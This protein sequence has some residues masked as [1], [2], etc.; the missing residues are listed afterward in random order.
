VELPFQSRRSPAYAAAA[1]LGLLVSCRGSDTGTGTG[2]GTASVSASAS[3]SERE[4]VVLMIGDG[5]GMEQVA[6]AGMFAH[7]EAGT[8]YFEGLPV[9]GTIDTTSL[10]GV[11][12]SAAAATAMACGVRCKNYRVGEDADGEAVPNLIELAHERGWRTG[13]VTTSSLPHATPAAFTSHQRSR[14]DFVGVA[15]DQALRAQPHVMLGGGAA[16]FAPAGPGSERSDDGLL[17]DLAEAGY[18][19]VA[20]RDELARA[21]RAERL[22]GAFAADHM[23]M[24][25]ER[26]PDTTQPTLAEMTAA[27]LQ[28]LD[29]G[30]PGMLLVV[31][32]G[33]IDHGGHDN[34]IA[35]VVAET[36]AFDEAV[37]TVDAATD[38]RATVIVTADHETG[39]LHVLEAR[40]AGTLPAVTWR[41]TEHTGADVGVWARN[42]GAPIADGQRTTHL[43][44]HEA[45]RAR[46][47]GDG[48]A[49]ARA[50]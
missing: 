23:D 22:F 45:I 24:V 26:A 8:L 1:A 14:Y 39:G 46:I 2:T 33:R 50:P 15:D 35:D 3:V 18:T 11:T 43:A 30:A 48:G 10:E 20:T 7:G 12:D 4:I 21:G 37:R 13:I 32:G 25:L 16:Y 49:T 31:E 36:L 41:T 47:A 27:A 19:I 34:S 40:G 28:A 44:I 5:M 17:D 42:P 38:E 29:G 9:R 6:A